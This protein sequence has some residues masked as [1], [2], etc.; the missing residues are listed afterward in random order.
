ML[1]GLCYF[2]EEQRYKN[3]GARFDSGSVPLLCISKSTDFFKVILIM[4]Q[5]VNKN[6]VKVLPSILLK[7]LSFSSE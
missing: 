6:K 4:L 5:N 3:L 1:K 2:P 7:I